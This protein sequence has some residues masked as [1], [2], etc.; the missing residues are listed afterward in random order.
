[1]CSANGAR[2][3]AD[4]PYD[5]LYQASRKEASRK[6]PVFFIHKYFARRITA[7]FRLALLG[8]MSDKD[9]DILDQFYGPSTQHEDITVLDPFMGG[10]TTVFEALR[11]GC[12][13]IGN[14]LQ[15]LS[16]FVTRALVE[17]V[18]EQAVNREV[19]KL[20]ST[21]GAQ[22]KSY[23]KTICPHCGKDAD[24]MYSFH[25]K[26]SST[27]CDGHAH[28]LFSSFII[29]YKKDIFTVVCPKCGKLS[30]TK[31]KDGP[32]KCECGWFLENP[33]YS[34]VKSGRF[35][36]PECGESRTL[37][38]YGPETGYPFETDVV[39]IE[40]CCPH[41]GDHGY[42]QP[43]SK[44]IELRKKAVDDF[45]NLED[46]LPIPDQLIPVG[47]NTNQI[48]NHGYRR[49]RDLF[50]ERQLLCLGLLLDAINKVE[51][52]DL[53]LWLQLAFSGM[54][55][56]NNM[57]CR[58]QQNAYK[59]C[60]IFFN[61]A[62]VPITMPVENCVWGAKLGTGTFIKTVQKIL[63]GKRFNRDIYDLSVSANNKGRYDSVKVPS[64]D[65][66]EATPVT[67]FSQIDA[68]HPLLKC[69]DSR[70]LSFVPDDSVDLVLTDPPYGA[71]V[72]YSELI[73][74]FHVWN[75]LSSI[76]E[77]LGFTEPL[78]PKTDEIVVNSVAGKDFSYYRTGLTEVLSECYSKV[79]DE[80]YL[81]FSFHD[82]SLDSWLAVLE[83]IAISGFK[84][85]KSYPVQ[86]ETRTGA[87][88]SNKN[89]IG[90]DIMLVSQ[91]RGGETELRESV[92]NL[93]ENALK[94]AKNTLLETLDRL[95]GVKAEVT[96]PDMQNI[97]IATF[98][99]RLP[100]CYLLEDGLRDESIDVLSTLLSSVE[101]IASGYDIADKRNGW[102][103]EMYRE[104]WEV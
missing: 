30:E 84:L 68:T 59:I 65:L 22:I 18:D 80:G 89:S 27:C 15:P 13:V 10:G 29:A 28:R 38:D 19:R 86:A 6:K 62:Y 35:T 72:M 5:R 8:Y 40:Y 25:V 88:T 57:F 99:S 32:F 63:R 39:A 17:P 90:I 1:M 4:M 92:S 46:E 75:Y 34:Y 41:C 49:F 51:D 97:V 82:K 37:S 56:M 98:Y 85:I 81:V 31:F 9:G 50:N 71:N 76:A 77:E 2:F 7:N 70:R 33:R 69:G 21:I 103:S 20:E 91:K 73:D 3:S 23:Y 61:H 12:K 58:Y 104:K 93:L 26:K 16:L 43:D 95:Q 24:G 79:K 101:E 66:V 96:V 64:T 100:N 94:Q 42:K 87:H 67:G 53:Q 11:F 60:N 52:K 55:E 47:Y 54:L 36:C 74:F 14:D 48:L 102:W 83:S 78:S 45:A 44:D